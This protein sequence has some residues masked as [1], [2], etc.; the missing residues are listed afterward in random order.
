MQDITNHMH[1]YKF[2][3][4]P[5][6]ETARLCLIDN[7]GRG[8]EGLRF[9]GCQNLLASLSRVSLSPSVSQTYIHY[10]SPSRPYLILSDSSAFRN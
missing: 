10:L 8:L 7:I 3:S 9:P 1:D 4:D 6:W 2:N 5:K